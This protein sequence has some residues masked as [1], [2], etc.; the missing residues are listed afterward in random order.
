MEL[1]NVK[2]FNVENAC[3]QIKGTLVLNNGYASIKS[4]DKNGKESY[5]N[6]SL[7]EKIVYASVFLDIIEDENFELMEPE[8]KEINLTDSIYKDKEGK[9]KLPEGMSN[10]DIFTILW[11]LSKD[12]SILYTFEEYVENTI[13]HINEKRDEL[14]NRL[15]YDCSSID[16]DFELF[17]EWFE[18]YYKF[19]IRTKK[20]YDYYYHNISGF[21]N[22]FSENVKK[23]VLDRL[24]LDDYRG[25]Y[26]GY[27]GYGEYRWF[28][29]IISRSYFPV[30]F[31]E[32][33]RSP[34]RFFADKFSSHL[35]ID[36]LSTRIPSRGKA[37]DM[38][39]ELINT[40]NYSLYRWYNDGDIAE[41]I[42]DDPNCIPM[43]NVI[44]YLSELDK[45]NSIIFTR[46]YNLAISMIMGLND[47]KYKE[48]TWDELRDLV[49]K[50]ELNKENRHYYCGCS[51]LSDEIRTQVDTGKFL[52][53]D[54]DYNEV[55]T[56]DS[57][58]VEFML[59]EAVIIL[60]AVFLTLEVYPDWLK[61]KKVH[62]FRC[63]FYK[64]TE[65]EN[66]YNNWYD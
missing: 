41:D 24:N 66:R 30:S 53:M 36:N 49:K 14:K 37:S 46:F 26:H 65:R 54:E 27:S 31:D 22:K 58:W 63:K 55:E 44:T 29:F 25:R 11:I 45:N 61:G 51:F 34:M 47:N 21:I 23:E 39:A 57:D 33:S 10:E 17:A 32:F 8:V 59:N 43:I 50:D 6:L 20:G 3:I 60:T 40:L 35:S 56:F 12:N 48:L 42:L 19:Y 13:N 28:E 7:Y 52:E 2:A 18:E 16:P 1:K 5:R 9:L 64:V 15:N 4:I 62:D 38:A